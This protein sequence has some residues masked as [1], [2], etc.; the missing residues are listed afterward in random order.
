LPDINAEIIRALV[1]WF[2]QVLPA[3]SEIVSFAR[4]STCCS[5]NIRGV[6]V[7][8]QRQVT[9]GIFHDRKVGNRDIAG[10]GWL[11]RKIPQHYLAV[12]RSIGQH[13]ILFQK[14]CD[15]A[16]P[17]IAEIYFQGRMS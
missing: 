7:N 16:Y 10:K 9:Y 13:C 4:K 5:E 8:F 12:K 15:G 6:I 2:H 11:L 1:C 14:G 3:Q 17:E